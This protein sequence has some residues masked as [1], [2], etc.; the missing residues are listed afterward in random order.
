MQGKNKGRGQRSRGGRNSALQARGNKVSHSYIRTH[1]TIALPVTVM[2]VD[3][4][5]WL[6]FD[7]ACVIAYQVSSK[8]SAQDPCTNRL[9]LHAAQ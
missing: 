1:C 6:R 8:D 5:R 3:M 2:L 9:C 4:Q 7:D